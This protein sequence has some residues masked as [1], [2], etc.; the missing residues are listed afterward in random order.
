MTK[1]TNTPKRN[2]RQIYMK[3]DLQEALERLCETKGESVS[4]RITKQAKSFLRQNAPLMRKHG[5][6]I[7]EEVFAK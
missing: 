2:T 5:I 1:N 6:S 7:P 4:E 3:A